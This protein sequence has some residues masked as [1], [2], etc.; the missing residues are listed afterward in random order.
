MRMGRKIKVL[1]RKRKAVYEPILLRSGA[2]SV[3]GV[4]LGLEDPATITLA[5]KHGRFG[6]VLLQRQRSIK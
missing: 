5:R 3:S 2:I 6:T 1:R 4:D